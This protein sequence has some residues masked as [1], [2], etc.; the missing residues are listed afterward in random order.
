MG[1]KN[2]FLKRGVLIIEIGRS[3]LA[4]LNNPNILD[5]EI[6]IEK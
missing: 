5:L 2:A 1:V 6:E 4:Y 3:S